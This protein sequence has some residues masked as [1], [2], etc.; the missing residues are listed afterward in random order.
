MSLLNYF[1]LGLI[2]IV[3]FVAGFAACLLVVSRSLGPRA[4]VDSVSSCSHN[5]IIR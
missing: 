3:S 1:F 5:E 4:F 2:A